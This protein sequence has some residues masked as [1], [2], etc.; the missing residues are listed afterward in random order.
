MDVDNSSLC[1]G[2]QIIADPCSTNGVER[3][4]GSYSLQAAITKHHNLGDWI[5]IDLH[6][7][8]LWRLEGPRLRCQQIQCLVRACFLVHRWFL[9]LEPHMEEVRYL[10][11][12]SFTRAVTSFHHFCDLIIS[13]RPHLPILSHWRLRF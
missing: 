6:F 7:S 9:Q 5:T 8:Q 2:L 11:R 1:P 3:T 4:W 12:I 13:P 10:S